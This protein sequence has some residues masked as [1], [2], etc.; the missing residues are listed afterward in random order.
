MTIT[1]CFLL[2]AGLTNLISDLCFTPKLKDILNVEDY[3]DGTRNIKHIIWCW[4]LSLFKDFSRNLINKPGCLN[5]CLYFI[6]HFFGRIS[7]ILQI[8][9]ILN[10]E[11]TENKLFKANIKLVKKNKI[12]FYLF[13]FNSNYPMITNTHYQ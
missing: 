12:I 2:L 3:K 9:L 13:I 8:P 6:K 10:K 4:V 11:N 1:V 7:K 5:S